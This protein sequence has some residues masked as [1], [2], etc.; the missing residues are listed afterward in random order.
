[1]VIV[2]PVKFSFYG[3]EENVVWD[4]FDQVIDCFFGLDILLTFL[5][6]LM[7]EDKLVTSLWQIAKAYLKFWFWVDILSVLPFEL[8]FDRGHMVSLVRLS[9]LPKLYRLVK[10]TKM[11][12]SVKASRSQS[13]IWT[14]I[15]NLMQLSPSSLN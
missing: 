3:D 13:N 9:R 4:T 7:L 6:P 2:L 12:R 8:M 14:Q 15:Y 5:T 10:I 1:V 11:I